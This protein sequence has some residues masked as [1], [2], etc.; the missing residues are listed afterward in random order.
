MQ[1]HLK[2]LLEINVTDTG[3]NIF[4]GLSILAMSCFWSKCNFSAILE[5]YG[6]KYY[7]YYDNTLKDFVIKSTH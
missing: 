5:Y 4:K 3:I 2:K 1:N 6:N 7:C